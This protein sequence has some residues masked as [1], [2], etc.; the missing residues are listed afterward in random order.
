MTLSQKIQALVSGIDDPK[1]RFDVASTL[2]FLF[3]LFSSGR[4]N[5]DQLSSDLREVCRTVVEVSNPE[6]MEDEVR[7]R[8]DILVDELVRTMKIEGLVKR[9][10]T[11][12]TTI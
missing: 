10:M 4:I 5:E 3:N 7:A 6:L 2:N 1:I 8:V 12:F 9:V 11:R